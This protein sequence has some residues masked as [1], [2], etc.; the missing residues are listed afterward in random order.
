MPCLLVDGDL[1]RSGPQGRSSRS[2]RRELRAAKSSRSRQGTRGQDQAHLGSRSRLSLYAGSRTRCAGILVKGEF[3]RFILG[4]GTGV[5]K[6]TPFPCCLPL[7][8]SFPFSLQWPVGLA[9]AEPHK[10]INNTHRHAQEKY[11]R[12][13]T[14]ALTPLL[15]VVVSNDSTVTSCSF[16]VWTI[17]R[18]MAGTRQTETGGTRFVRK[19]P[20]RIFR[21]VCLDMSAKSRRWP[22]GSVKR[23]RKRRLN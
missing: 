9:C 3:W 22:S 6:I 17:L 5:K 14:Q 13:D 4:A 19:K 21:V 10:L 11:A 20:T 8:Q 12:F 18:V 1:Q 16:A 15:S 7:S 2:V 23:Q